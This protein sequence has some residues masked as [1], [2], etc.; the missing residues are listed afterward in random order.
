MIIAANWTYRCIE[1]VKRIKRKKFMATKNWVFFS[2]FIFF[3]FMNFF[4]QKRFVTYVIW[5]LPPSRRFTFRVIILI[6]H[7][8][9]IISVF[10]CIPF[11]AF[12]I[13]F[14]ILLFYNLDS[15]CCDIIKIFCIGRLG[16]V[17]VNW[18]EISIYYALYF[19]RMIRWGGLHAGLWPVCTIEKKLL[20]Y[21]RNV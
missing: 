3:L 7:Y 2:F 1:S 12:Y 9:F 4:Q 16:C 14:I 13:V 19:V 5:V 17:I 21:L 15:M 8:Y 6:I 11:A 10:F 20:L 18:I